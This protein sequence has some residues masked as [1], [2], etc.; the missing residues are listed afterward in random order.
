MHQGTQHAQQR[1]PRCSQGSRNVSAPEYH[2]VVLT[3]GK[4]RVLTDHL[5]MADVLFYN[6]WLLSNTLVADAS[7]HPGW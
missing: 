2:K 1:A 7:M 4:T 6:Q 5:H 3:V